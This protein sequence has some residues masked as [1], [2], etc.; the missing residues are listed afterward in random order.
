M[1]P[2]VAPRAHPVDQLR[3]DQLLFEKKAKDMGLEELPQVG[4]LRDR[5]VEKIA[6]TGKRAGRRDNVQVRMP[7]QKLPGC[8]D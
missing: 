6:V 2:G 5:G 3:R 4:D 8:L 1:K 7:V